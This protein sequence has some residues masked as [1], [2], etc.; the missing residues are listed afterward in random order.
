M[1]AGT[2]GPLLKEWRDRV[3]MTQTALAFAIGVGQPSVAEYE[4]GSRCP[5]VET[6]VKI[7]EVTKGEVP[8][9]SW[10]HGTGSPEAA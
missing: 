7:A 4:R 5:R 8:V 3:G 1:N 9:E 10:V 2:G 6:A